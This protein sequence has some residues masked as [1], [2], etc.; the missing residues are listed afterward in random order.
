[1][2]A[3]KMPASQM[4]QEQANEENLQRQA[5]MQQ[6]DIDR[7]WGRSLPPS[8]TV[9][10]AVGANL[11]AAITSPETPMKPTGLMGTIAAGLGTTW[12]YYSGKVREAQAAAGAG[13]QAANRTF[14]QGID[15]THQGFIDR[16]KEVGSGV[17]GALGV[18]PN[19]LLAPV[20]GGLNAAADPAIDSY[21][22]FVATNPT[23]RTNIQGE[24]GTPESAEVP[25]GTAGDVFTDVLG[26]AGGEG[27]A[28]EAS[29]A[30]MPEAMRGL[31]VDAMRKGEI[32]NPADILQHI[33]PS[34][35]IT[36]EMRVTI[37]KA[38][39]FAQSASRLAPPDASIDAILRITKTLQ[40]TWV[41]TGV[42]PEEAVRRAATDGQLREELLGQDIVGDPV[43]PLTRATAPKPPPIEKPVKTAEQPYGVRSTPQPTPAQPYGAAKPTTFVNSPDESMVVMQGLE[44][45]PDIGGRPQISRT[46]AVGRFQIEPRTASQYGLDPNRL[47]DPAYNEQ[48]ARVIITDL[49]HKFNGNM[50]A[51]AI[52]YNDGEG[53]A[54]QWLR[55]GPGTQLEAIRDNTQRSGWRYQTVAAAHDEKFMPLETQEYAARARYKMGAPEEEPIE[56]PGDDYTPPPPAEVP[57]EVEARAAQDDEGRAAAEAKADEQR[58][59]I[60]T[61]GISAQSVWD[62]AP[63][64]TAYDEIAAATGEQRDVEPVR[65]LSAYDRAVTALASRLQPAKAVDDLVKD[66]VGTDPEKEFSNLDA[67]RQAAHSDDRAKVAM[68]FNYAGVERGGIVVRDGDV[69]VKVLP[70]TPT[71]R[72]AFQQ[73]IR[74][75]GNPDDFVRW[76]VARRAVALESVGKETPFNLMAAKR[77]MRDKGE[78]EKYSAAAQQWDTFTKGVRDYAE[79]SGRYSAA[80]IKGMED[81]D[82]GSWVSFNRLTGK[83]AGITGR[84]FTVGS[85]VKGMKGSAE[86]I[87]GDPLS[88]SLDNVSQMF[89]A[90]D[91]NYA[92]GKLVTLAE[93]NPELAATLGIRKD[94]VPGAPDLSAVEKEMKAFGLPEDKW[95]AAHDTI[96]SLMQEREHL[97][98]NEFVYY[99]DGQR[100]VWQAAWPELVQMIKGSTPV[101]AGLITKIFQTIAHGVQGAITALPDFA[102]KMFAS[103]QL[104]QFINDPIHPPPFLTGTSGV[105]KLMGMHGLLEDAMAN[106]ALGSALQQLD[107]DNHYD[108]MTSVLGETG[109]LD[110]VRNDIGNYKQAPSMSAAAKLAGTTVLTP[111]RMMRA[112]TERL[113]MGNRI[114]LKTAAEQKGMVPLKAGA[115]AAEYGID[116]TNKGAAATVNWWSSMVPFMRAGLLYSEQAVKAI[117]RNPGAYIAS[118]TAAVTIPKMLLYGLNA[119]ADAIPDGQPGALPERE[120]Y[121]NLPAWERLYFF[122][123]PPIMGQRLKLRMP[124]FAAFPFGAVPEAL[125]MQM[126]EHNPAKFLDL[127]TTFMRDFVPPVTPPAIQAPLEV[128]TNTNLETW[129][130]LVA[131]S[132][133]GTA[134]ELRYINETSGPAKALAKVLGPDN[135]GPVGVGQIPPMAAVEHLVT[136][137]GDGPGQLVLS[138]LGAP[139]GRPGAP[140]DITHLPFA[141]A[142]LVAHPEGGRALNDYYDEKSQFDQWAQAKIELKREARR[143]DLSNVGDYGEEAMRFAAADQKLNAISGA[144]GVMRD[145]IYGI[146]ANKAMSPD[147]KRQRT[148]QILDTQMIP[149]ALA[150]TAAMR[151]AR[152][153]KDPDAVGRPQ[154]APSDQFGF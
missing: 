94:R 115:H 5:G 98:D 44:G 113:D 42:R 72:G 59:T 93:A 147:E 67:F 57:A 124:D 118:A 104:V 21:N 140:M 22:H 35:Q 26:M 32:K 30:T 105:I 108:T 4:Q 17:L 148:N 65:G 69:G 109:W 119:L 33:A 19:F 83:P 58:E 73:A 107:R 117:E 20:T 46:G 151:A 47:G 132:L 51:M 106:G 38:Q 135:V 137:W 61:G 29:G 6:P 134:G 28:A 97:G 128:A 142:F 2:A 41:D 85:P 23:L 54:R 145:A 25:K 152:E 1:M 121:R 49:Y 111:F 141:N 136:G 96:A 87:V 81:A 13:G 12:D 11:H 89:K 8:P 112:I 9:Q 131:S 36:P 74:D 125:A 116:Y 126:H 110:R 40:D 45:S 120:K 77:I 143:G 60:S 129:Q 80:Q 102:V 64:S 16:A 10:A 66:V 56:A 154:A 82:L 92:V 39:D 79:K 27:A 37:P 55:A 90:A 62:E 68:G 14:Y 31:A 63:V 149:T 95:D 52:A 91:N 133:Q 34:D 130:P 153:G 76:L 103:H 127:F 88:N 78:T 53:R 48:A 99:R 15:D 43:Q 70:N 100:E 3:A 86:G 18:A 24:V 71:A 122:I 139:Q 7:Y 75:G 114:G 138:A 84:G 150:A 146:D 101:Q 144:I 50:E 123:T